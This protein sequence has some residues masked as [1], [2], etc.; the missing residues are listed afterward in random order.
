MHN[1]DAFESYDHL[2]IEPLADYNWAVSFIPWRDASTNWNQFDAVIIRSPWDYQHEPDQFLRTL[3]NIDQSTALLENSLQLVRWNINKYYLNDLQQE[4]IPIVPT[5]WSKHLQNIDITSLFDLWSP[6][7]I[8]KP[9]ISAGADNTF[10]VNR[11]TPQQTHQQMK[12]VFS[13]RAFMVQPFM[14]KIRSEG[15]FSLFYFAQAYSHTIL[16]TPKKGDF[17]VQEEHG[18]RLLQVEPEAKLL[19]VAQKTMQ[20]LPEDPLYARLDFVRTPDDAFAL[21]EVE[22]IEPSLYF[23]MDP[24]SPERFARHFARW[25]ETKTTG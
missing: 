20:T 21:M 1:L 6:E 15:E 14:Q 7:I 9:V 13:S 4:G 18:G 19:S 23:N 11:N 10:W 3:R 24:H 8:I 5:K 12:Q 2:L 22:L 25:M 16:K 17:R